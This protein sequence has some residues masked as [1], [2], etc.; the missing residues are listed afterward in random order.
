MSGLQDNI[1]DKLDKD[2]AWRKKEIYAYTKLLTYASE[3]E[4]PHLLRGG[5][6]LLYAH[7]EGYVREASNNY[8][9]FINKIKML[10]SEISFNF[11]ALYVWKNTKDNHSI[12]SMI[13]CVENI[14]SENIF[15]INSKNIISTES[16][17]KFSVLKKILQTLGLSSA[18]FAT[19]EKKL[20]SSLVER[21]HAIAHGRFLPIDA[22]QYLEL[23]NF[24]VGI[25]EEFRNLI[26]DAIA[27]ST[28][29]R[30]T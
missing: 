28:Y 9:D 10:T 2:L 20:D 18:T 8:I 30:I 14:Y 6:L 23:A 29:R 1:T 11:L 12:S 25:M 4:V 21:R 3:A 22:E 26:L 7:W 15:S 24:T 17:L 5:I 13:E 19:K 16:D 27:R